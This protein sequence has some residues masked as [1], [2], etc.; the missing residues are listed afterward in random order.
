METW[1]WV[2]LGVAAAAALVLLVALVSIRRRRG[3]L[4]ERFG[5]EYH[6]AVA[7][8]GRGQAERRLATVERQH[9]EL[10]LRALPPAARERYLDEWRQAEARFVSDLGRLGH[11]LGRRVRAVGDGGVGMQIDAHPPTLR[12]AFRQIIESGKT[13][14][15]RTKGP[16]SCP[17]PRA[18]P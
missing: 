6:R 7:S 12:S 13:L 15:R 17:L 3:R 2:V 14:R 9:E 4:E 10:D 8:N 16:A 1:E 5:P 11:Q 18:A